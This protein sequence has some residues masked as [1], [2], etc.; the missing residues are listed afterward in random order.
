MENNH[1]QI[2]LDIFA[3]GDAYR[4]GGEKEILRSARST[5]RHGMITESP[6]DIICAGK[7]E[8]NV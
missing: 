6:G 1:A 4:F 5:S 3:N 7:I 2:N 8:R